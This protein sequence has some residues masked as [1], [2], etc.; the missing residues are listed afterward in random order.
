[1]LS[2]VLADLAN[3]PEVTE[4]ETVTTIEGMF[5]DGLPNGVCTHTSPEGV[6]VGEFRNGK[7]FGKITVY[8][9]TGEILN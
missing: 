7:H 2:K 1:M 4:A 6:T 8:V 5:D 9:K 3:Q